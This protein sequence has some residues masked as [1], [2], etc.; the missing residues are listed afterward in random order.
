MD[1]L[2]FLMCG[3]LASKS[4]DGRM[5][6]WDIERCEQ[7]ASWKVGKACHIVIHPR[8]THSN[9][10]VSPQNTAQLKASDW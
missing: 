8:Y 5:L 1:C 7:L 10:P 2:R 4:L 9:A 3:R 6:I